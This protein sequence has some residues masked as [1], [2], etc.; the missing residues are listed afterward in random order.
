MRTNSSIKSAIKATLFLLAGGLTLAGIVFAAANNDALYPYFG[1][2]SQ[3]A[4]TLNVAATKVY[5]ENT[6]KNIINN[7]CARCHSG[8]VRNLMEYDQLKVYVDNQMLRSMISPGGPMSRFAG[9]DADIILSWIDNGAL[10]KPNAA[11]PATFM[12]FGFHPGPGTSPTINRGPQARAPFS[13]NRPF[14]QITYSN[15]IKFVVAKDCLECHAGKFRNLTT[16]NSLKFYA[17]SG[18]LLTLVRPGGEMHRFSGP[19]TCLFN[20]WINNGTPK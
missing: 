17:D 15:T 20:A 7:D 10:E 18:L 9:S 8:A 12:N 1:Y 3:S 19:D 6:I 14:D 2:P 11:A 13:A 16:Y 5:Y 4:P